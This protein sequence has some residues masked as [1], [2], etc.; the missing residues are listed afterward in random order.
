M[1]SRLF[2]LALCLISTGCIHR[3]H[4]TPLPTSAP[5]HTIPRNLKAMLSP[6]V[7]EGPDH[8]PGITFLD[9]SHRDLTQGIIGYLRQRGTF[10]SVSPESGD[11]SLHVATK[12]TLS[13]RQGRYHYRVILDA[14]M[15]EAARPIKSYLVEQTAVGSPVRWVTASDRDPIQTALQSALEDLMGKIETDRSLYLN[16]TTGAPP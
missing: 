10:A 1:P 3:I 2:L 7:L 4:V 12:L 11:L 9:W 5:S 15:R 14:E 6:I 13:S 16:H 8:R